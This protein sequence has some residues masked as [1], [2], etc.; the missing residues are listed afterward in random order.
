MVEKMLI[1]NNWQAHLKL[2]GFTEEILQWFI[3]DAYKN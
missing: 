2:S 3:K 1:K